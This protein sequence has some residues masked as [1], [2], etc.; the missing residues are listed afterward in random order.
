MLSTQTREFHVFLF[1]AFLP[2]FCV[3]ESENHFFANTA[4]STLNLIPLLNGFMAL[5]FKKHANIGHAHF[6]G[7]NYFFF[8]VNSL[9]R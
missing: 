2:D 6:G 4:N 3:T 7:E 5:D 8:I 9:S 1:V